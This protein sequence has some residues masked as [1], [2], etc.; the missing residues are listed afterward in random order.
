[1]NTIEEIIKDLQA[2]KM[3]VIMDDEDRENEGDL[4]MA[5]EKLTA[6]DVNFM[7][8]QGRGL[9]CLPMT[10]SL[11][12]KIGIKPMVETNRCRFGTNFTVSIEAESGVATGISAKD[13]AHTVH[14]AIAD[15]A[16]MTD[17]VSPGHVFPI[18]AKEGGVLERQG[19]TEAACDLM[20]LAGFKPTGVLIEILN[21]DGSMARRPELEVF[22]ELHGL[23][24]GTVADL[25]T[26]RQQIESTL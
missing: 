12:K 15:N 22:A 19:H 21:A 6:D 23:K 2:G 1:V 20:R 13:R 26:Y 9:F 25:V 24:I 11:C 8:T 5:A 3:V 10:E 17:I 7:I 16:T 18:M 4:I 14:V